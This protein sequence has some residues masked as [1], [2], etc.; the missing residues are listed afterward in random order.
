MNFTLQKPLTK[1]VAIVTLLTFLSTNMLY[2]VPDLK[3]L[4]NSLRVPL[5]FNNGK[6]KDKFNRTTIAAVINEWQGRGMDAD[7]IRQQ[8]ASNFPGIDFSNIITEDATGVLHVSP[9]TGDNAGITGDSP[10]KKPAKLDFAKVKQ[11]AQNRLAKVLDK[12]NIINNKKQAAKQVLDDIIQRFGLTM[13]DLSSIGFNLEEGIYRDDTPDTSGRYIR[14]LKVTLSGKEKAGYIIMTAEKKRSEVEF[15]DIRLVSSRKL[16]PEFIYAEEG[17]FNKRRDFVIVRELERA[18]NFTKEEELLAGR[19][20]AEKIYTMLDTS[21]GNALMH[22]FSNLNEHLFFIREGDSIEARFID[23]YR[24]R[25]V[26]DLNRERVAED[27]IDVIINQIYNLG[28]GDYFKTPEVVLAS[29]ISRFREIALQHSEGELEFYNNILDK[30]YIS[31]TDEKNIFGQKRQALYTKANPLIEEINSRLGTFSSTGLTIREIGRAMKGVKAWL[32]RGWTI[33]NHI[34]VSFHSAFILGVLVLPSAIRGEVLHTLFLSPETLISVGFLWASYHA[35][36]SIHE[37]GHYI[38]SVK[39]GALNDKLLPEAEKMLQ[40]SFLKRLAWYVKMFALI[41]YGK[42]NGVVKTGLSYHP[43]AEYNMAQTA[44]GPRWSRNLAIVTL[45]IAI[46]LGAIGL[47]SDNILPTYLGRFIFGM[48]AVGFLDFKMADAGEYKKFQERER[49]AA[50]RAE[51]ATKKAEKAG[52]W[53]D[54]V[55]E[56]K[57]HMRDTRPQV[58]RTKDGKLIWAPW[59]F[60]NCAMGGLHTEKQYPNSNISMQEGMYNP[61]SPKNYE[62]AQEMTI[63][64]QTRL[65]EIIE[66]AEGCR[67]MGIGLEGGLAPYITKEEGDIVPEQRLWRMM[68]QA[69]LDCGYVPGVDV[70]IALDP[71]CSELENAYREE[72]KDPNAIGMYLFWRDKEKVVMTRDEMFEFFK[73]TIEENDIPIVS[74]EDGFAEDDNE[75]WKRFKRELGHKLHIIGD[76]SVTTRDSSIEAAADNEENNTF[77]C[78]ANQIGTLSETL[79]AI[80]VA[81]GKNLEIVVSHRSKSP[82]DDMEAQIALACFAMGIKTGGGANTERLMKY[83]AIMRIMAEA[84]KEAQSFAKEMTPEERQAMLESEKMAEDLING[85]VITEVVG[86]EEATNAGIPTVK[87][88]IAFGIEG[89]KKFK[90]FFVYEGSTPLGTSAGTGEAIHLVDSVIYENQIPKEEHK[91][92][93][94][95]QSDGSYRFDK[96]VTK[97]KIEELGDPAL[98]ELFR[99][100][101]RYEGKGCLAAV[102]H[103]NTELSGSFKG[104]KLKDLGSLVDID[105]KQLVLEMKLAYERGQLKAGVT[106]DEKIAIMQRKGNLGMNAILS[107]SLAAARLS[108]AMQ[109]KELWEILRENLTETMAKTIAANGGV[110]ILPDEI[111]NK[112]SLNVNQQVWEALNEQLSFQELA[113]GLQAVNKT[114]QKDVKLYEL[115]REQ[116]PVYETEELPMAAMKDIGDEDTPIVP[117]STLNIWRDQAKA[118]ALET[119]DIG[120]LKIRA[121]FIEDDGL[122]PDG[123]SAYHLYSKTGEFIIVTRKGL[124]DAIKI[125][126]LF[127]EAKEAYWI[128][129]LMGVMT[130]DN[131]LT[132]EERLNLSVVAH[133]LAAV[134]QAL[135]FGKDDL[136]PYHKKQLS[137]MSQEKIQRL[138]DEDRSVHYELIDRYLGA[139]AV[140]RVRTYEDNLKKEAGLILAASKM[141][142][143]AGGGVIPAETFELIGPKPTSVIASNVSVT[144]RQQ[145]DSM[146][147]IVAVSA[148]RVIA[149]NKGFEAWIADQPEN[150]AVVII[151]FDENEYKGVVKYKDHAYIKIVA[152]D[153]DAGHGVIL[154]ELFGLYGKEEF[155]GGFKLGTP[156]NLDQYKTVLNDVAKD[157]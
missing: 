142:P 107:Q 84:V 102:D 129:H 28:I 66:A 46:T 12:E 25:S 135:A 43:D 101:K 120:D 99:R 100:A 29:F 151:A 149:D 121:K 137:D 139:D 67:V 147:Q 30:V 109:G 104:L 64:L 49:L 47:L 60:R 39:V 130:D 94:K 95:Q 62:D 44:A 134:E 145:V 20:L 150:I 42:F 128:D 74:V 19:S 113:L 72:Y 88:R 10:T 153:L 156:Y 45:P 73:K 7:A 124:D 58:I 22:G 40:A 4:T 78:K 37:M 17:N 90:K 116:L 3:P 87:V 132:K 141:G 15:E 103:V 23:W 155:L 31:L 140:N 125:E 63:K 48:G 123:M 32:E 70:A 133:R 59:Q 55:A 65:Q 112:I 14:T 152:R 80:L 111:K 138:L 85:L 50:L 148:E 117:E 21:R 81:L 76:D 52:R 157:I 136:T 26:T 38:T 54:R 98:T 33:A 24:T 51:E 126:A 36:V 77:L 9:E 105:R 8:L 57:Q 144:R 35:G 86:W 108:A 53:T 97:E 13:A 118:K 91:T 11:D 79:L 82:N 41:P 89:S 119:I 93:F 68:K 1:V 110:D 34:L 131:Q 18:E 146:D 69:I 83:G 27:S 143:K 127:H 61:L 114:K 6:F 115:L 96:G 75:G 154:A 71:A 2:A 56:V 122:M 92:L 16:G 5:T 106:K